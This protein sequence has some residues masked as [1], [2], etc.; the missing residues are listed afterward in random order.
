[1]AIVRA[2]AV[3]QTGTEA[4]DLG[5]LSLTDFSKTLVDAKAWLQAVR[6]VIP[7]HHSVE[8]ADV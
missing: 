1:M 6:F 7:F 5:E 8:V 4:R 2:R 3:R